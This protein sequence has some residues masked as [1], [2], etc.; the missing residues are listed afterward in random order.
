MQ[1]I[2]YYT[3]SENQNGCLPLLIIWLTGSCGL[4]LLY[5]IKIEYYYCTLLAQEKTKIE[6]SKYGFY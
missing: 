6:N 4:L 3:E 2:E 5:S 1:F